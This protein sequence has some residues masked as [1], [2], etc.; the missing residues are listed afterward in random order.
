[1]N[2]KI[3]FFIQSG[4]GG[5]ERIT[6]SF[7]KIL[8]K[9]GYDIVFVVCGHQDDI[10]QLIPDECKIL[11]IRF[12]DIRFWGIFR[13]VRYLIKEKP[14]CVFSS[15]MYINVRVI[16][17]A[18]LLGIKVIIRNNNTIYE[19][20]PR[21]RFLMKQ[22]YPHSN[23]VIAQQEEM[24]DEIVNELKIPPINVKVIN[25]PI[26]KVLI[27][28]MSKEA[29]PYISGTDITRYVWV[30]RFARAKGQDILIQ[31]FGIVHQKMPKAELYFIGKYDEDN[32]IYKFVNKYIADHNLQDCVHIV[33][34]Q[35]NPHKWVKNASCFVMPSRVEGLPNALV[36][37]MY[38]GVPVVATLCIPMVNRIV[39]NSFNGYVVDNEDIPAL[40]NAMIEAV[41]LKDF[42]M[43]YEPSTESDIIN[44]FE[45]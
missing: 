11:R 20:S 18:K 7:A 10:L 43:T 40:A 27:D 28:K 5:A 6:I 4:I 16:L 22:I 8:I 9:Q 30:G 35:Y 17:A 29:S 44:L 14:R 13:I 25:N 26:D 12:K 38:I 37:A 19:V 23:L 21:L 31:A 33:G 24:K 3:L 45:Q 41:K 32:E 1:M 15:I 39:K 34:L 42:K 36:E 2:N